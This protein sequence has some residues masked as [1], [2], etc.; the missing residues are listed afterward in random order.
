MALSREVEIERIKQKVLDMDAEEMDS[1]VGWAVA[2]RDVR[3]YDE[4]KRKERR[5]NPAPV[6]NTPAES[7]PAE[8]K[9]ESQK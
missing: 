7:K 6:A 5:S 4:Q 8:P 9:G 1:F 3:R 2:A